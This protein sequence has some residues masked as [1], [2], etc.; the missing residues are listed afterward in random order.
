MKLSSL[1]D[2]YYDHVR[3]LASTEK[4]LAQA[5]GKLAEAAND[6]QL[7]KL[8]E[9]HKT[10]T[11]DQLSKVEEI[12]KNAS[13]SARGR[14]CKATEGMVVDAQRLITATGD[15][16]VKDAA[17]AKA[18]RETEHFEVFA[19]SA[20]IAMAKSLDKNEDAQTFEE[21][22][23]QEREADSKLAQFMESS[24]GVHLSSEDVAR[25]MSPRSQSGRGEERFATTQESERSSDMRRDYDDRY[26]NRGY[27]NGGGYEGRSR[28]GQHSAAMQDRDEYGRFTGRDEDY[29]RGGYSGGGRGRDYDEDRGGRYSGGGSGRGGDITDSAGRHYTEESWERAQEGRSRGGQHSHGGYGSDRGYDE[30]RGSSS[31]GGY[32]R[33]GGRD[34][35][36]DRGGRYSSGGYG[37]GG[38]ITDS[39]GRHYSRESWERAQEGRS[40]GGQHSHMND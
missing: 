21:I 24:A 6:E 3:D 5:L 14:K 18:G 39:A 13:K 34:Y 20:A 1:E 25:A 26:E 38:D 22:L 27:S 19:Y 9:E 7:K 23:A 10:E 16:T 4:Q 28:G 17:L 35:D 31:R 29:G 12:L 32:S 30:D 40:R 15:E 33:G 37:R 2:V 8:F 36:E 11:D